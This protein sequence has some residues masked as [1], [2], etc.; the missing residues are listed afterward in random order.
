MWWALLQASF[1][2]SD[3]NVSSKSQ[4]LLYFNVISDVI[5]KLKEN[6][7]M[8]K[9]V[10]LCSPF[11][12]S[13]Q[14][15][16]S[17]DTPPR[18][19]FFDRVFIQLTAFIFCWQFAFI[20]QFETI[21]HFLSPR[22]PPPSMLLDRTDEE[23]D[24]ILPNST[25]HRMSCSNTSTTLLIRIKFMAIMGSFLKLRICRKLYQWCYFKR[26]L[27]TK[28]KEWRATFARHTFV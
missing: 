5:G 27:S 22:E 7:K 20:P 14:L 11:P 18:K 2:L 1:K 15:I 13:P 12:N 9:M 8:T 19:R 24:I 28:E 4:E 3:W 23:D 21:S 6:R 10:A 26:C 16:Y 25:T 17:L